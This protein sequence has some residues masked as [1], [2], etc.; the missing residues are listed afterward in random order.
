MDVATDFYMVLPMD[1]SRAQLRTEVR[2]AYDKKYLYVSAVN[3][4]SH[5]IIVESFR[6]DWNFGR[7]DNFIFFMD[8]FDDQ[9]NGF[10][11]GAN[12]VGAEWDGRL[13]RIA[14]IA[15]RLEATRAADTRGEDTDTTRADRSDPGPDTRSTP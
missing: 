14:R 1:T 3:F 12:A 5:R 15:E 6:R 2:M 7:N 11:F 9:T 10:T 8:P 4:Q 13:R